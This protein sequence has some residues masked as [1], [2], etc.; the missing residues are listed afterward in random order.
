MSVTNWA[1][2]MRGAVVGSL[3]VG[4]A[5]AAQDSRQRPGDAPL[6]DD[7]FEGDGPGK[8]SVTNLSRV[9]L[10]EE[11]DWLDDNQP[12]I[13]D[14]VRPSIFLAGGAVATIGG[15]VW[16]TE[17]LSRPPAFRGGAEWA[18]IATM[19]GGTLLSASMAILVNWRWTKRN[20]YQNRI[21]E[22]RSEFRRREHLL[23][24]DQPQAA[25]RPPPAD[26]ELPLS[27][28]PPPPPPPPAEPLL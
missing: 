14:L 24:P 5:A 25:P 22:I 9:A 17:M 18:P 28:P 21:E 13:G 26:A 4:G 2:I 27:P 20:E 23:G 19:V 11:R 12:S 16:L 15:A 1:G 7:A 3:L 6:A 10:R 8:V